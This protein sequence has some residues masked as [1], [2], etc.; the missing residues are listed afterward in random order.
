MAS[1]MWVAVTAEYN[2][3]TFS[4]RS[5]YKPDIRPAHGVHIYNGLLDEAG[6]IVRRGLAGTLPPQAASHDWAPLSDSEKL[7]EIRRILTEGSP[8]LIDRIADIEK[9]VLNR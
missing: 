6:S 9:L 7:A 3:S 5:T 8:R 2:G 1:D 4:H